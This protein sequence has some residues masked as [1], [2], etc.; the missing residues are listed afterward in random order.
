[1]EHDSNLDRVCDRANHTGT[2][3]CDTLND[4]EDC[5][6]NLQILTDITEDIS[7]LQNLV[8]ELN[9]SL[10]SNGSI[11]DLLV[12]LKNE[13]EVEI[14]N[15]ADSLTIANANISSLTAH[16]LVLDS[17]INS[18]VST[19]TSLQSTVT[20]I[21]SS[22]SNINGTL[23]SFSSSV[24]TNINTINSTISSIQTSF[25]ALQAALA[26][27]VNNR[28][29]GDNN[30]ALARQA[31]DASLQISFENS[32]SAEIGP[33][34]NALL[35]SIN[36]GTALSI[37]WTSG[38]IKQSNGRGIITVPAGN[39]TLPDNQENFIYASDKIPPTYIGFSDFPPTYRHILAKVTTASGVITNIV[40]L[41]NK[42]LF[43]I[44]P[45]YDRVKLLGGNGAEGDYVLGAGQTANFDE[46]V[47]FFDNFTVQS[48]ATLN[49]VKFAHIYCSGL[50]TIN[51]VITIGRATSGAGSYATGLNS[52]GNVGGFAGAGPGGGSGS[53]SIVQTS[54]GGTVYNWV[55]YPAGSGGGSGIL[56]GTEGV[57]QF[58][59]GGRGGGGL[60][61]EAAR[62]IT[63]GGTISATGEDGYAGALLPNSLG[64]VYGA[65]SGGG[66]GSGGLVFLSSGVVINF[67]SG[68]SI[69][70]KGGNGGDGKDKHLAANSPVANSPPSG[71][72][73]GGGGAGGFII[74]IAPTVNR[75]LLA[76]DMSGGSGGSNSP[77]FSSTVPNLGGGEGAGFAGIGGI[78]GSSGSSGKLIVKE[79]AFLA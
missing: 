41:R 70:V 19:V 20:G 38:V 67:N 71:S 32:I 17:G 75:S 29:S 63:V 25:A 10:S 30:E 5:V 64:N 73:G 49:I 6:S 34:K 33:F 23:T 79:F 42:T 51:G 55:L 48:G 58:G 76:T 8:D 15:L 50:V 37:K 43:D 1:M 40:D 52:Q 56:S 68:S 39:I 35:V 44:H 77:R 18:I 24:T 60:K 12:N 21:S 69:S 45:R 27:E 13:L 54:N 22:L 47:Y 28:S 74:L 57:G 59:A 61:I 2:Q 31:A 78:S 36:M 7:T 26:T 62:S 65:C 9:D 4:L 14:N 16:D 3:S 11:N 66:G 53:N 46:G 72:T